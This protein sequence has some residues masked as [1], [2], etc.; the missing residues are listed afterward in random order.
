MAS[1]VGKK[2]VIYQLL[3]RLFGNKTQ[4]NKINGSIDE[5]GCG[6]FEDINNKALQAL[7]D[8]GITHIWYTGIIEHA[9]Q[10]D[11]SDYGIIKDHPDVVKGKAGSAYA[12]KDY[13]DVDPDLATDVRKRF[14]EFKSLIKRTHDNNLKVIIDFIPNHLARTYHSDSRPEGVKDFGEEDRTDVAFSPNNNFYYIPKESFVPPQNTIEPAYAEYPAK[15]TGN[16][17]FKA[18]PSIN[19]WYETIKL[20]YGIDYLNDHKSHF[21]P[22]PNTWFKMLEV[23]EFWAG[24]GVD[25]FRCDMVELVPV[26]FWA[27]IIPKIKSKNPDLLFIAEVYNPDRY[28]SYLLQGGFDYLYDKVELYD[29]LKEILQHRASADLLSEIWKKQEGIADRML[30]FLENHDEQRIASRFF[31][32]NPWYAIPAMAISTLWHKG[33]IM[34]YFGQ[35]VGEPAQGES[36]FSGDDGRTTIFDYWSVPEHQKWMNNGQ[37]DGAPLS[38]NQ[39]LLRITYQSLLTFA[40]SSEAIGAGHFFDLQYFNRSNEFIGYSNTVFS[41]LRF[42][43][44]ERLLIVVN[45]YAEELVNIKVPIL[46]FEMM[47]IT[48]DQ[49]TFKE[50]HSTE[51]HTLEVAGLGNNNSP[52]SI[53]SSIN[54][55]SYKV[56]RIE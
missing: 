39:Q 48:K 7:K 24:L 22:V 26:E 34:V 55:N 40:R 2:M 41:F 25:G 32:G 31:I 10:T 50:V 21:E 52:I 14:V 28:R 19:D 16:D 8:L 23:L 5:N 11:Y 1:I 36:G 3:P 53:Q 51:I 56:F 33:P 12:I 13:F 18:N 46:A 42:S 37:F 54:E 9:T 27:W 35:E 43:D 20:N 17:V 15:A 30:R 38:E 47:K 4:L 45:F 49:I 44:N 29:R 6:T